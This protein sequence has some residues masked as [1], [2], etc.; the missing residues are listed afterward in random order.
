MPGEKVDLAE[1]VSVTGEADAVGMENGNVISST[2]FALSEKVSIDVNE[3]AGRVCYFSLSGDLAL[4]AF[5]EIKLSTFRGAN[6]KRRLKIELTE[7]LYFAVLMF[8]KV[9]LHCSDPLRSEVVL[10]VLEEHK[11]WIQSGKIVFIFSNQIENVRRDYRNYI[12]RKIN[13][14]SEGYYTEKEST[15]LTQDHITDEYYDRVI[16]LL[17][18]SPFLVRKSGNDKNTS[19][20]RLVLLDLSSQ[21]HHE[22]VIVDSSADISQVLSL[23]LSL[24]QLLNVRLLIHERNDSK[25]KGEF[26]FPLEV[27]NEVSNQISEH[28]EQGNIIAR[29]AIV[30]AITEKAPRGSLTRQKKNILKAITLRMDVLY[31]RMN[32]GKQLILEFHPSYENRSIYQTECFSKYLSYIADSDAK[33]RL[34]PAIINKVLSDK[35]LYMF[36]LFYLAC[37]ADTRECMSLTQTY[38]NEPHQYQENLVAMFRDILTNRYA[39]IDTTLF[40]AIKKSLRGE[41]YDNI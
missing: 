15:S 13:D 25:G 27:V 37:M 31:C 16:N 41:N 32:S 29:S 39:T 10:N 33:I 2:Q 18:M 9:V 30:D 34:T 21:T 11:E 35:Y 23:G 19:F 36:R 4:K 22:H 8:D 1:E 38:S 28:L 26:A 7:R 6:K 14:Y 17:D 3:I 24:H 5:E 40:E 20:D 12:N